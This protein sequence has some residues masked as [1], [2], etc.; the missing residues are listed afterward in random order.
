MDEIIAGSP[1]YIYYVSL[2]FQFAVF[3]L[4]SLAYNQYL[5]KAAFIGLMVKDWFIAPLSMDIAMT[6]HHIIGIWATYSFCNTQQLS[7]IITVGEF[8]SGVYN[9]YTLAKHYDFYV[10]PIYVG[11]AVIMTMTNI[12][13]VVGII[14]APVRW[15]YKIPCVLLL[16]GRQYFVYL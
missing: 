13:C 11:Y 3:P 10:Y 5:Y 8:G 9:V 14:R 15:Y 7:W 2:S 6:V 16:C 4:L 1:L 12:Y